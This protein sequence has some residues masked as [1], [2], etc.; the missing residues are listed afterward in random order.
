MKGEISHQ[1]SAVY[2]PNY[3]VHSEELLFCQFSF[4]T[5]LTTCS[6]SK[7]LSIFS[8]PKFHACEALNFCT[9]ISW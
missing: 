7:N 3:Q 5:L 4:G 6:E 8:E 2:L 1:N 9:F